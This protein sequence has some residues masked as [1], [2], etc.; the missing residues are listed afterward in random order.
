[1]LRLRQKQSILALVLVMVLLFSM[2][3]MA[4][5]EGFKVKLGL[6]PRLVCMSLLPTEGSFV[7]LKIVRDL[8]MELAPSEE[9]YK[10]AGLKDDLLTGGVI[11][12]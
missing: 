2:V 3:A 10:A 6:F 11:A 9:E 8:Q 12:E 4:A 5:D 1:M 7:T